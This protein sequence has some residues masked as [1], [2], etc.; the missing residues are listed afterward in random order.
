MARAFAAL[1]EAEPGGGALEG[2]AT[3]GLGPCV[4]QEMAVTVVGIQ[5]AIQ[6]TMRLLN[7]LLLCSWVHYN[8]IQS[9][10]PINQVT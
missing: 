6:F 1:S 4:V 8:S 2:E 3:V 9:S 5:R 10:P 7:G